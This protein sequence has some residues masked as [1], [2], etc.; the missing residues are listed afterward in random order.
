MGVRSPRATRRER[1][2][3]KDF[4]AWSPGMSHCVCSEMRGKAARVEN[5]VDEPAAVLSPHAA[6]VLTAV[7]RRTRECR[8]HREGPAPRGGV[9]A[10]VRCAPAG[11]GGARGRFEARRAVEHLA[12]RFV[13]LLGQTDQTSCV[14]GTGYA[15]ALPPPLVST[16]TGDAWAAPLPSPASLSQKVALLARSE[17]SEGADFRL[18]IPA[19]FQHS[20]RNGPQTADSPPRPARQGT[21]RL[22]PR[23][24]SRTCVR[25]R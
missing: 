12:G 9:L 10:G 8:A 6:S 19:G 23:A 16:Q 18:G 5:V 2:L 4:G 3:A 13:S 21:R 11:D 17:R 22:P 20:W 1:P 7:P 14:H 15:P 24:A 25:T